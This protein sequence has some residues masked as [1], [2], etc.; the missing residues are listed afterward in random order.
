MAAP[1]QL[2]ALLLAVNT[3]L[4]KR[5]YHAALAVLKGFRNGAVYGAKIRAPH[6]LV[7][8][9]LF[10]SGSLR[11]KL[12]AILQATYTHSSNL[13]CFVFTYKGLCALQS[14]V[15]GETY[16]MHSFL[17]AFIGGW[18]VFRDNNN[19]NSQVLLNGGTNGRIRLRSLG[20]VLAMLLTSVTSG[21]V[22]PSGPQGSSSL[23]KGPESGYVLRLFLCNRGFLAGGQWICKYV[24]TKY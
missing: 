2:R 17:A 14:H 16:Q 23:K 21:K 19:I 7:M 4:R 22:T 20:V 6:S 24:F 9:F 12:Q 5:R 8:T 1:P 11:E 13:A 3:L 18:L 15:Q 10:R